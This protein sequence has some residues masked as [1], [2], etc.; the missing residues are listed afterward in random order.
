MGQ[1]RKVAVIG[2]AVIIGA[3][4]FFLVPVRDTGSH[5]CSPP[6]V[7]NVCSGH[8]NDVFE[9]YESLGCAIGVGASYA[10][11]QYTIGCSWPEA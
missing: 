8:T 3:A 7:S 1:A 5:F 10:D 9:S 4:F 11:G 6:R 2:A